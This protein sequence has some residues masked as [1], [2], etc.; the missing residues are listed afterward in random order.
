[1]AKMNC[2]TIDKVKVR[3]P[4]EHKNPDRFAPDMKAFEVVNEMILYV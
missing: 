3:M 4:S 2:Y 1:M